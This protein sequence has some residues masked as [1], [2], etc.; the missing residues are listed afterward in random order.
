M[1]IELIVVDGFGWIGAIIVLIAYYC[2]SHGKWRGRSLK[3]NLCNVGGSILVGLS[4]LYHG[5]FPSLAINVVWLFIG[6]NALWIFWA[7][8]EREPETG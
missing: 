4:A 1:P 5:A 8:S 3:Y 7:R 6:L 2:V